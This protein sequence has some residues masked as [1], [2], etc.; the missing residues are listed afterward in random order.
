MTPSNPDDP[1]PKRGPG[2]LGLLELD[3]D[4]RARIREQIRQRA[5]IDELDMR[6]LENWTDFNPGL[7]Q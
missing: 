1:P 2:I 7:P 4:E 3:P 6:V 5:E